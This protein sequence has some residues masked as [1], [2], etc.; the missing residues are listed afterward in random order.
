MDAP[1]DA[2]PPHVPVEITKS[3]LNACIDEQENVLI[4][5]ANERISKEKE[6]SAAR[7]ETLMEKKICRYLLT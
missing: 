1:R 2:N 7:D 5:K 4:E 3:G 6:V